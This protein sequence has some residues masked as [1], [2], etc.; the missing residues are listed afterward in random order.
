VDWPYGRLDTKEIPFLIHLSII[1]PKT[2]D[3]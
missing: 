1:K 2:K 3:I